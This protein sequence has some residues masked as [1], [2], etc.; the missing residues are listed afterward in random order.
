MWRPVLRDLHLYPEN[1]TSPAVKAF[2]QCW[3]DLA[4]DRD[5]MYG[6]SKSKTRRAELAFSTLPTNLHSH[7][8]APKQMH[9][10]KTLS[11]SEI[12]VWRYPAGTW[13]TWP[14]KHSHPT[15]SCSP[16]ST[17]RCGHCHVNS[18]SLSISEKDYTGLELELTS[19]PVHEEQVGKKTRMTNLIKSRSLLNAASHAVLSS[20][21]HD[22][23]LMVIKT[24]LCPAVK[25]A[26]HA[27]SCMDA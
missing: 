18:L 19:P 2:L 22:W 23:N 21:T 16:G 26:P 8:T 17:F 1:T 5:I 7:T 24:S 13:S 14:C 12:D 25:P 4:A 20:V 9:N 27:R 6:Y 10:H 3:H 11:L 15:A